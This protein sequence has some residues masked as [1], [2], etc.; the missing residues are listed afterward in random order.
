MNVARQVLIFIIRIYQMT[1]SPVL[2]AFFGP[3]GCCRFT[4]SCSSY[5]LEAVRAHGAVRGGY[6]AARRLCRCHPWGPHGEDYP[7]PAGY[8]NRGKQNMSW[9]KREHCHGS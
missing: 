4:P 6:L 9:R 5:A 3:S 8:F 2:V 7:P 1:I